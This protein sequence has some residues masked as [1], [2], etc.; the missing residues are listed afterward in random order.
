MFRKGLVLIILIF[1]STLAYCQCT[2]SSGTPIVY[3]TFGSGVNQIGPPLPAGVTSL[4][5]VNNA[6]PNDGM[7]SIVNYTTGCY[8]A[9]RTLTDHTGDQNGYFMLINA[10]Y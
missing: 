6:C 1:L 2:K 9:W 7:Y 8:G 3:E 5:F 4:Q 10:S